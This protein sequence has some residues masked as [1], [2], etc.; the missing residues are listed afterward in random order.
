MN[1]VP[2]RSATVTDAEAIA[3]LHVA[4]WQAAYRG[5][6]ADELLDSLDL[7]DWTE[8]RRD[9]LAS[10]RSA[11]ARNWVVETDEGVVGWASAGPARAEKLGAAVHEI[12]AIYLEPDVVGRGFGRRLMDHCLHD[13]QAR[14]FTE[15]ILW[16]LLGNARPDHFYRA[17]GFERDE[18]ATVELFRDTKVEKVRLRRSLA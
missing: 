14:G 10:P 1:T 4:S 7:A 9:M 11:E 2:V 12:Y 3:R 5:L 17:A 16:V 8:R 6:L 18:R 13:A 15:M